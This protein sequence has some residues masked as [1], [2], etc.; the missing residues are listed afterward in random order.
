M[1]V[2]NSAD[3]GTAWAIQA[4]NRLELTFHLLLI[5]L[6]FH[7]TPETLLPVCV[8]RHFSDIVTRSYV[9]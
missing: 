6:C 5:T 7:K 3:N 4:L 8:R 1:F 9:V 2:L